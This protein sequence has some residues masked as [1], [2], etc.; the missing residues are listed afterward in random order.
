MGEQ[1]FCNVIK[2]KMLVL[3]FLPPG[4]DEMNEKFLPYFCPL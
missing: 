1:A 2:W 4:L 3:H